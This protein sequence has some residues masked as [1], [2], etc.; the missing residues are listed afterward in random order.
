MP[1]SIT[2]AA[3]DWERRLAALLPLLGHR[4]WI[5]IADS[6]YP[7][8]SN[9]GIETVVAAASQ[10][11]V[12]RKVLAAID[13]CKHVRANIYFDKELAFVDE[14]DAPGILEYQRQLEA[15]LGGSSARQLP[16]EDIIARLDQ[17]AQL[18]RILVIKTSMTIP[19][20]S[21]FLELDCGYWP[22]GAE[23]RLRQAMADAK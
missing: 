17:S 7:A 21:V 12:L 22:A 14:G 16:H 3:P 10:V 5:V 2:S 9:P 20:T 11:E 15:L 23:Q 19:Y 1:D 4:N 18:F 8:Q 13:A 6:A